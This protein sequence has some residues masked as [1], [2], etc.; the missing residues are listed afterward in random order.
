MVTSS[1]NTMIKQKL[2]VL[3]IA[4]TIFFGG[5]L[6]SRHW[7]PSRSSY[8]VQGIDVSH[9]QGAIDWKRVAA[10]GT[11]FAYIKASEGAEMRDPAFANNW[12]DAGEAGLKRGAYHF[13]TLCKSGTEQATNFISIVERDETTLPPAL[14]LEFGGN[15]DARP[16][17][18]KLLQEIEIFVRMVEAHSGKPV[19]LYLT[20]EFDDAYQI[21]SA[22]NRP[23]WLRRL[24]LQ[25]NYG[26]RNW[27]MWQATNFRHVDG[28]KG[29]VDWNVLRNDG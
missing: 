26:A 11:D 22:V 8:P 16:D 19:I 18:A 23:L 17:K 1:L 9:H 15:C 27:V 12:L 20:S 3:G 28:I 4:A 6:Y 25:P 10:V 5:L 21:S 13:F 2:L 29:R 14:D 7:I 24:I